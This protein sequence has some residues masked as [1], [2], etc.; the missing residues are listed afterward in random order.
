MEK[1]LKICH[2]GELKLVEMPDSLKDCYPATPFL[3]A[4]YRELHC[5]SIEIVH[6]RGF[7]NFL[8]GDPVII[9]D[10]CGKLKDGYENRVN[11]LCS[12]MYA[13]GFDCIVGDALLG[14]QQGPE[15]VPFPVA[16]YEDFAKKMVCMFSDCF[17]KNPCSQGKGKKVEE[18]V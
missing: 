15:V 9:I 13:P 18:N 7:R 17:V 10:E 14:M 4:L 6:A 11:S 8:P 16:L 12:L 1:W 5:D 3:D 2:T